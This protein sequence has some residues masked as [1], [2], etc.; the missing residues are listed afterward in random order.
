MSAQAVEEKPVPLNAFSLQRA[1][2]YPEAA[3]TAGIEGTVRVEIW[4]N[5]QGKVQHYDLK[6][7]ALPYLSRAVEGQ[8]PFLS[9]QPARH[10]GQ[11]V[12]CRMQLPFRFS[13]QP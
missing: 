3:K 2:G 7:P 12:P 1:I 13:L 8:I 5:E 11:A 6:G 9:F 4:V 10:N